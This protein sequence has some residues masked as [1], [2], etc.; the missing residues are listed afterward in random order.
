[1]AAALSL[2]LL[3]CTSGHATSGHAPPDQAASSQAAPGHVAR[4][5][6][7]QA[8]QTQPNPAGPAGFAWFRPGAAPA[9]WL[10]ASLPGQH[11]TLFYPGSLRPMPGDHGTVTVGR[12]SRSGA[13]L[14][15]LN[16]TPRQGD[17]TL[18][19]WPGFRLAHL[20]DD[21]T[22]GVHLDSVS[23]P[24]PFHGGRGRCVIDTYTTKIHSNRYQEI[25]CFVQGTHAASVLVAATSTGTWRVYQPLLDQVVS[26]YQAG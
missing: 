6:G 15:Y 23:P 26:S 24:L 9:A 19:D 10:R 4:G 18:R 22:T 5:S 3:G 8:A 12:D 17:E 16:V 21:G 13:V 14:V 2:A 1:M 11:A 25:A 7:K 20:R